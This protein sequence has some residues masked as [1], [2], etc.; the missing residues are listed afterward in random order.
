M[1]DVF[2]GGGVLV[3]SGGVLGGG[4]VLTEVLEDEGDEGFSTDWFSV[5]NIGTCEGG[6]TD[7]SVW[8][9]GEGEGGGGGI[10]TMDVVTEME[11]ATKFSEG[12][13]TRCLGKEGVFVHLC[14]YLWCL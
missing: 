8:E 14:L 1:E 9:G 6:I 12:S 11:A 7:G 4:G 10:F 3:K 5:C 2:G 13:V